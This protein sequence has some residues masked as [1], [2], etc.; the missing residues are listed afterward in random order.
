MMT[1]QNVNY[2]LRETQLA[3]WKGK[4]RAIAVHQIFSSVIQEHLAVLNQKNTCEKCDHTKDKDCIQT[5]Q[6][7]KAE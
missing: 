4:K 2:A 7:C 3:A 1:T 6:F 5:M